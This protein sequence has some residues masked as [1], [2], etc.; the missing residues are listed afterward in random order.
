MGYVSQNT[1]CNFEKLISM[2]SP[3]SK[4]QRSKGRV[5]AGI[6]KM[7]MKTNSVFFKKES[8]PQIATPTKRHRTTPIP[9]TPQNTP[10]RNAWTTPGDRYVPSRAEKDLEF[11]RFLLSTP[12]RSPLENS[13]ACCEENRSLMRDQLL[14]LKGKS[15]DNRVMSFHQQTTLSGACESWC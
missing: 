11:A 8:S 13:P 12:S 10:R 14:A 4:V 1:T 2:K 6:F 9:C 15:S 7:A 5:E 3:I